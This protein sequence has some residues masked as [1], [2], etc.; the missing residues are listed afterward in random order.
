MT[1]DFVNG[2]VQLLLHYTSEMNMI[3]LM[4][5]QFSS[6]FVLKLKVE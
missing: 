6:I 3:Y 2:I 1:F 5:H 4:V